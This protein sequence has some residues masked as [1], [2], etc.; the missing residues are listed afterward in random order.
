MKE[1]KFVH[2]VAVPLVGIIM[3][4]IFLHYAQLT[5]PYR[6]LQIQLSYALLAL[7]AGLSGSVVA[8]GVSFSAFL[9]EA[10]YWQQEQWLPR[11]IV[12]SLLGFVY[13]LA[14]RYESLKSGVFSRHDALRF[15]VVQAM[16]NVGLFGLVLPTLEVFFYGRPTE[17]VFIDGWIQSMINIVTIAVIGTAFLKWYS[18]HRQRKG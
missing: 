16:A 9:I 1:N 12:V 11:A 10:L 2:Y 18:V 13:G 8:G 7:V 6:G 4:I 15:N 17:V 14:I 3:M 5:L